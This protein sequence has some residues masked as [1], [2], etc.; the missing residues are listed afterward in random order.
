MK[1][2][3]KLEDLD[4]PNCT[5]KIENDVVKIAGVESAAVNL[6]SQKMVIEC[7]ESKVAE[8]TKAIKKIVKKYE[9][10]VEVLEL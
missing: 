8:I 10:D 7:D 4:C 6:L 2:N 3:Y 5:A 9:P 1:K